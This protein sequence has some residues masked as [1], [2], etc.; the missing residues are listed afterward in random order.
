MNGYS[1]NAKCSNCGFGGMFGD[2]VTVEY[3]KSL[4]E[5]PCPTCGT[6]NLTIHN[7]FSANVQA[8]RNGVIGRMVFEARDKS[9]RFVKITNLVATDK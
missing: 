8:I 4:P 3:G 9:G 1:T 6:P 5:V 7:G 2:R